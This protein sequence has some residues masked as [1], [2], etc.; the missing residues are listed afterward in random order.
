MK[1]HY[2]DSEIQPLIADK[3]N[4]NSLTTWT[5]KKAVSDGSC[6]EASKKAN[7]AVANWIVVAK[8]EPGLERH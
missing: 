5:A 8:E 1:V 7:E 4:N 6:S 3:I 2:V